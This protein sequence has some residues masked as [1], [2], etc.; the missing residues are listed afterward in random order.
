M[1]ENV[2]VGL[3]SDQYAQETPYGTQEPCEKRNIMIWKNAQKTFR[4]FADP[5]FKVASGDRQSKLLIFY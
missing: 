3:Q 5:C 4:G 2:K 1:S